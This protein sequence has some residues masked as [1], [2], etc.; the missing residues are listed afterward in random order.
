MAERLLYLD[1]ETTGIGGPAQSTG[2]WPMRLR[3]VRFGSGSRNVPDNPG[4]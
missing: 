3:A 4:A 2:R 1:T